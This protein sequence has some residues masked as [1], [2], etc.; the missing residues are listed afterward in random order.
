[1]RWPPAEA[2]GPLAHRYCLELPEDILRGTLRVAVA[3]GHREDLVGRRREA[4][5]GVLEADHHTIL[6]PGRRNPRQGQIRRDQRHGPGMQ[7]FTHQPGSDPARS[8]PGTICR[9]APDLGDIVAAVEVQIPERPR[10]AVRTAAAGPRGAIEDA[11][12]VTEIDPGHHV[13]RIEPASSGQLIHESLTAI[14][15]D[16]HCRPLRLAIQDYEAKLELGQMP[17]T[18]AHYNDALRCAET[19]TRARQQQADPLDLMR[20]SAAERVS[21]AQAAVPVL[22]RVL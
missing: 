7:P 19:I 8:L 12:I 1:M 4:G 13:S 15:Q 20:S 9:G 2:V 5:A 6:L 21:A 11:G 18:R 22:F 10:R 17:G 14:D 3:G 16:L